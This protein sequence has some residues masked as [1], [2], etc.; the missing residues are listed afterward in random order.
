MHD[1]CRAMTM[2]DRNDEVVM[3]AR[4]VLASVAKDT[5]EGRPSAM[6]LLAEKRAAGALRENLEILEAKL[7]WR[8]AGE[9]GGGRAALREERGPPPI[10]KMLRGPRGEG[11]ETRGGT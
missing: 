9:I 3:K 2:A 10:R 11:S 4:D 6:Q 5:S 7:K 1:V 8:S